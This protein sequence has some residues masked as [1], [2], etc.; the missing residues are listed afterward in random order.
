LSD[1]PARTLPADLEA[2]DLEGR[3]LAE[4]PEAV[5]RLERLRW[6]DLGRNGLSSLPGAIA[7]PPRL[8]KLDL[9]WNKL[10]EPPAWLAG[11]R[12]RG[13]VVLL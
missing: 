9:R 10:A 12:Q 3:D 1:R 5:A 4:L 11:V 7:E 8:E 2:L 6:L 13:C